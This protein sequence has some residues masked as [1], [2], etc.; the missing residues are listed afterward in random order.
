M[1]T[2][3]LKNFVKLT[4]LSSLGLAICTIYADEGT[5]LVI[6]AQVRVS[7]VLAVSAE[8]VSFGTFLPGDFTGGSVM[9]GTGTCTASADPGV[10]IMGSAAGCGSLNITGEGNRQITLNLNSPNI[11]LSDGNG[12]S[13]SGTVSLSNTSC[14]VSG[15]VPLCSDITL[16]GS[17]TV[18][19][20]NSNPA[21]NYS[22]DNAAG[23]PAQ[24]TVQ[25]FS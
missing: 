3:K 18:Q 13:I 16:G 10:T 11:T 6:P 12:H 2:I 8:P 15:N 17:L 9:V 23:V 14:Y 21:G 4:L 24:I 5:S 20:L 22:T 19:G 1:W 25:Y 7:Q